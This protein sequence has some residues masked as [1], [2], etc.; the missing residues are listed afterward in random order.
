MISEHIMNTKLEHQRPLVAEHSTE[1][2]N[3]IEFDESEDTANIQKYRSRIMRDAIE[4]IKHPA[5]TNPADGYR[6]SK[7]MATLSLILHCNQNTSP[8]HNS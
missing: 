8:N 2:T 4:R 5:D 3:G 7:P 6:L 1:T